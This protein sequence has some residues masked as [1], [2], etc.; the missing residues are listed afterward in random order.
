MQSR[1]RRFVLICY[2]LTCK[3]TGGTYIG[4]T[5]QTLKRRVQQHVRD[6]R[7]PHGCTVEVLAK[8]HTRVEINAVERRLVDQRKPTMNRVK[9]GTSVSGYTWR[10]DR[11]ERPSRYA[12]KSH[13]P[14]GH[15]LTSDVRVGINGCRICAR[16]SNRAWMK[17]KYGIGRGAD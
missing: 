5:G 3:R 8:R 12:E 15:E 14:R 6:G 10:T 7:F 1:R 17:Q 13:C 9:G 4:V 2:L 11:A 16:N